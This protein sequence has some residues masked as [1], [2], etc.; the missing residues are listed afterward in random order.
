MMMKQFTRIADTTEF[1]QS[2]KANGHTIGFVPTMGALHE[3]HLTLI[4]R[5]KLENDFTVCSIFVNPIQFNNKEDLAKYPRNLALDSK[6]LEEAGCD[7]LF[8]PETSEMYPEGESVEA[9]LDFGLLDKV[10]EGRFRPGHFNGVAIVVKKLFDIVQ[11][12]RAYFG[13]KDFQ[14]LAIIRFMVDTLKLP[15]EVIPC[16]TVREADGLAMSSRNCR[17]TI[18]ERNLAP[19]IYEVLASV[20]EKAGKLPLDELKEWAKKTI[21]ENPGFRVEY[22]EIG[23]KESLLPVESWEYKDRAVALVAV[24]LG[25]V[26]LIDNI[27]LFS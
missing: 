4:K 5:S 26:R 2:Q 1:L 9:G 21:Q 23:D 22:F 8:A 14:Q 3:G 27:E 20:R 17:L 12:T 13:K 6:L 25:D 11:P 24:F 10:M 7:V 16:E 15:L 19:K 18:A